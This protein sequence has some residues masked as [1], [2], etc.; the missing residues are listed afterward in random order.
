VRPREHGRPQASVRPLFDQA[1][2]RMYPFATPA[3]APM[4]QHPTPLRLVGGMRASTWRNVDLERAGT[5][6][7]CAV[8]LGLQAEI[9]IERTAARVAAAGGASLSARARG[10]LSGARSMLMGCN[11]KKGLTRTECLTGCVE[12]PYT[13]LLNQRFGWDARSAQEHSSSQSCCCG[14]QWCVRPGARLDPHICLWNLAPCPPAPDAA[15][16][17][18]PICHL[19]AVRSGQRAL[20][21]PSAGARR[22]R[23]LA[24]TGVGDG[25]EH[26]GADTAWCSCVRALLHQC[27]PVTAAVAATMPV[28]CLGPR[29]EDIRGSPDTEVRA[30]WAEIGCWLASDRGECAPALSSAPRCSVDGRI[31]RRR[32]GGLV[33]TAQ[34]TLRVAE[35]G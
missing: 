23:G 32:S 5:A 12:N 18:C 13:T 33:F 28:T 22:P 8:T 2:L 9:A 29:H 21:P 1:N 15:A 10:V 35:D 6:A 4:H 11:A 20:P 3:P 17:S 19:L 30:L 25:F 24:P 31:Q 14:W 34:A 27:G 16:K 7:G 26:I